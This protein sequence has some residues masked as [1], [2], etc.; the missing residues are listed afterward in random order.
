MELSTDITSRESARKQTAALAGDSADMSIVSLAAGASVAASNVQIGTLP[1]PWFP[2]FGAQVPLPLAMRALR[3]R[4]FRLFWSGQLIS[5]IG[6]WMQNIARGWLVLELTHSPFWLGMVGFANSLP[7]LLLSLWAGS[8]ADR[9]PKRLLV[10]TTQCISMVMAFVL[11]FLTWTHAVQVSHLI[12]ISLI[13]GTTFAFD[14]P[15]RQAFTVEMVGGKE[16]L[17]NA[18]ALN[19]SIFNGAR[20]LGPAIGAIALAWQGPALAFFLNGVSY[21]AVIAGLLMM[22]LPDERKRIETKSGRQILEGLN[23]VRHSTVIGPLMIIVAVVSVFAFP[24]TILMP[25]FADNVLKVGEGGYGML[26]AFSGIGSLIG[27]VSLAFK[28]GRADIKRGRLIAIGSIGLP[29]ALIIFSLSGNYLLSLVTLMG[30]GWAMISINATIN[31]VVQTNVPDELRGRVN[32]VFAFLFVG[33]APLGNL[34]AGLI[35]DH[36]GAPAAIFSG[37]VICGVCAV[38]LLVRHRQI[39]SMA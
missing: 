26:M 3:H 27:A 4:N 2:M 31:T 30:V 14:G 39:I 37:A 23:F 15:T 1:R 38:Y 13:L 21:I 7:V 12:V 10:I 11:A 36:F 5:L 20:V 29:V 24:Y 19:S 16:D 25:I 17:M 34:Q 9:V 6:T 22:R 33:M 32:G 35:A 18:V 28:S 8:I